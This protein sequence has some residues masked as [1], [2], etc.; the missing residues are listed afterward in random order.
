MGKGNASHGH[1][2]KIYT[3]CLHLPEIY[4]LGKTRTVFL[5]AHLFELKQFAYVCEEFLILTALSWYPSIH[6]LMAYWK[7]YCFSLKKCDQLIILQRD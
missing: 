7:Y 3:L 2:N 1:H 5:T 4:V 6:Q